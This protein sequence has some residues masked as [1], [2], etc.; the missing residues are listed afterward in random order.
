MSPIFNSFTVLQHATDGYY[1]VAGTKLN[2]NGNNWQ[3]NTSSQDAY[4]WNEND[5]N[6]RMSFKA[7]K[8]VDKTTFW[9][10]RKYYFNIKT[11]FN[12][13]I[14]DYIKWSD[15]DKEAEIQVAHM[16]A[17]LKR[18]YCSIVGFYKDAALTQPITKFSQAED[19]NIYVKY[20]VSGAPF[21]A[22][23][24]GESTASATWY[25]LTD[26]GSSQTDGKK[27][28]LNGTNFKNNG[29]NATYEKVSEFAFIGD[30][31]E[32][33]VINRSNNQ[34]VGAA[35]VSAGN[36][37]TTNASDAGAGFKWEIPDDDTS[38]SFVMRQYGSSAL[39]MYWQ[40]TTSSAG[41]NVTINT[42]NTRV[43]VMELEKLNYTFNVINLA[44]EI[45]ITATE[46]LEPFTPLTGYAGIPADIRSPFLADE[47]VK[48]YS[49]YGD[50]NSDGVIDRRDWHYAYD[51]GTK[52]YTPLEKADLTELP[53]T[54][55]NIYVSYTTS[56]LVDKTIKLNYENE[57]NVK[58]NDEYIYW[59]SG[60]IL[61]KKDPTSEEL[62]SAAYL[63][64]LRGRDPYSMLIDNKGASI[65]NWGNPIP[66]TLSITV[67]DTNGKGG[68]SQATVNQGM[69][70]QVSDGTWG[71]D[72]ALTFVDNRDVASRFVA[73]MS[74][75]PGV[76]EVLAAT[77][78]TELY[79]IGRASTAG[80]ETKIYSID[81]EN[82]GYAHGSDQLRFELATTTV[83]TY[84][85][86]DKN[87]EEL[88]EVTSAN[89]R[90]SFPSEYVSPLVEEY[91]YYST[92]DLALTDLPENRITEI[93][94]DS[95]ADKHVY[96]TYKVGSEIGFGT[97]HPYMLKF[98]NGK[99][100]KLED[101]ND[102]LIPGTLQAMYPY[103][104]GDGN[105]NIYDDKMN[106]EQLAGG[107]N[108]RP[109]WVWYLESDRSDPYHVKIR[110]KSTV[111][112][113]EKDNPTYL[114]TYAVHFDQETESPQKQRIVTGG[115]LAGISQVA[116]TEY[117]ILGSKNRYKLLTSSKVKAD[118]NGDGDTDDTVDRIEEDDRRY[119]TSFEQY[120]KTYNMV[121]Q[122]LLKDKVDDFEQPIKMP[123]DKWPDL[124]M[125][126]TDLD[127]N[128]EE[129]LNYVDGCSW[130]SY[131]AVASAIR[132]NG[133]N[134]KDG[135]DNYKKR[136]VERLEHW[137]QSFDM[138]DG[139]F[140]IISADIPPVLVL[141][142][143]HGWEIMRKPI[144]TGTSD[145]QADAKLA[146]LQVYDSPMVKEYKFYSNASK[147]K[148]CH[149]Y[150]LR[151]QDGAE[152]DPIKEDGK[153]FTSTSLAD[154]PQ[155]KADRDLFVTYT[156]KEEYDKSYDASTKESSA[157]IVLQNGTYATDGGSSTITGTTAP[158][159]LSNA[160]I[161][162]SFSN[163]SL[164]K[165]Q[166][167]KDIDLEMGIPIKANAKQDVGFDPYNLQLKNVSTEKFFTIDMRKS[168]LDGGQYNGDYTGGSL[169]VTL[170]AA[171]TIPVSS[172][173]SYD[174]ST[175]EMTNQTFMA[176]QDK[177]GNMQLM[178]R[179][180]HNRRINAF[181]TLA[182]PLQ[183]DTKAAVDDGAGMGAQTTFMV[184]P[185]VFS[186]QIIDNEGNVALCYKTAGES[187]P[188]IPEHFMS[189][190][191]T[192]F[193]Y[194]KTRPSYNSTTKTLTVSDEI[195]GSFAE[196]GI[197]SSSEIY[198]RY[199]YDEA[200]D[201]D[202][203]KILQGPWL[204]MSLGGE[205]QWVYY[206][207]T[208]NTDGA[209]FYTTTKPATSPT[210]DL[211]NAHQWHW[212]FL[213]SPC[214]AT[215]D[216]YIAPD[217]YAIKIFNRNANKDG[218]NMGVA[219]QVGGTERFVLLS[220]PNGDYALAACGDSYDSY[221]FLN[222]NGM[223]AHNADPGPAKHASL[224]TE[225]GFSTSSTTIS[226]DARVIFRDDVQHNYRYYVINNAYKCAATETQD[227]ETAISNGFYPLLPK[228]IQTE[229]LNEDDYLYYGTATKSSDT[230]TIDALTQ[231]EKLYGLYDDVIYVRY[232]EQFS[233]D[234]TPYNVPNVKGAEGSPAHVAR[235]A[236]S[237]D[238]AIDINGK[239]PYNIVWYDDNMMQ[240]I[241]GLNISYAA[242]HLLDGAES[243]TWKFDG[244]DPYAIQIKS[245]NDGGKFVVGE[246]ALANSATKTFMLL[247]REG[248]DYGVLAVTGD[249][250]KMLSG[251][252][253]QLV[254]AEAVEPIPP[255]KFII[256]ALSVHDLIYHLVIS[257]TGTPVT[258]TH[259][260][261][262]ETTYTEGYIWTGDERKDIP[263]TTQRDLVNYGF[264][265][266][267]AGKVSIGDVLEVPPIM[268]RPN[269]RYYYYVEG[270]YSDDDCA[271]EH[272]IAALENKYKGLEIT[273]LMSDAALIGTTVKINVAYSFNSGLPTNAGDGFVTEVK[274][275]WYTF[276]T[277]GATPYL[278]HYT[279]AL[280]HKTMPGRE[281]RFTNDYLWT[282]LGDAYG[283]KMYNRYMKKNSGSDYVMTTSSIEEGL[284]LT[285]QSDNR[286]AVYEL[287]SS[288]TPGYF[289]IHPVVNTGSPSYYVWKDPA[290][291][292]AK[293]STTAT[294][295]T[296]GLDMSLIQPYFDRVGYL[297]GLK[298]TVYDALVK[299]DYEAGDPKKDLYEAIENGTVTAAQLMTLQ[300]IVYNDD[301]IVA[302][303]PGYYRLHS[304]PGVSEINPVRYA[305][306]YLHEIEKTA[307][308]SSTPIPMHFYSRK[309]VNT[310]FDGDGGLGSGF[311]E[312]KATK[313]S[314]PIPATEYDPSTIF[315]I[316]GGI[317]PSDENDKINPRVTLSTQ[318]L[319]VKGVSAS[320]EDTEGKAVMT[321]TLGSAT[322]FSL[323][324][325]GGAVFLIHNGLTPI[326]REYFHFD[327]SPG[328]K[329]YDL[330]YYHNAPTDDAKWCIEP[331]DMQGLK[332]VTHDGGDGYFYT[333]LYVPFDVELPAD[334]GTN[335]Y[336][337]YI[338][339]DW[340]PK[341]LRPKKVGDYN[342]APHAGSNKF[343]PAGTQ[344]II[345]TTDNTGSVALKLPSN[346]P[347]SRLSS[348]IFEGKYLEQLLDEEITETKKNY[349]FGLPINGY[350][351][352]T[353]SGS[354]NGV[355]GNIINKD[356]EDKGVGFYLNATPNKE[357]DYWTPNNRYVLHNKIYYL[358]N[359]SPA[360]T[361][362]I[363]FVPVVFDDD[364][365]DNEFS[366][367]VSGIKEDGNGEDR[368]GY[369]N[370]V[371]DL[372]GRCVATEEQVKDGTWRMN[373]KPGIYIFNGKKVF[374][375]R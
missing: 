42:T 372:Q 62:A 267:H 47:T 108:T 329:K 50:L 244:G 9:E 362:G 345:R 335:K 260:T 250:N 142:D 116:A 216:Y 331:A 56:R 255:T 247:K 58:L 16:P 137:F 374:V 151:M 176:V 120:W 265:D 367:G 199:S 89:P 348:C 205:S 43:K 27:L 257:N 136:K 328:K 33:R 188:S 118:L 178:P 271:V 336:N 321:E 351:L 154:L 63:W 69:F 353:T 319:Y 125:A 315:Y 180:D 214:V 375:R 134:D 330:K 127:I 112:F 204:T 280:G 164:W 233:R 305:S 354:S 309:G 189:P 123:S 284:N 291:N 200:Q 88:L 263:G 318:D 11:Q 76:Y 237:N 169:N 209:G 177:K 277:S 30:P 20:E 117:M 326:S 281:T 46:A 241:D 212:K 73:M 6:V 126:L 254:D 239:L 143:R 110:S 37:L 295:W 160:I 240:T 146:A 181:A 371:Y 289:R 161:S 4:L 269:C 96:V 41:N 38:G 95:D 339:T 222:G 243:L 34:Y 232:P 288:S 158:A 82:G 322:T 78:T 162:S 152:R 306:G 49:S 300:K 346:S 282:P 159:N 109:R 130:H 190:L 19:Y 230:Y 101:G 23:Q 121:K 285:M 292:Y 352:T 174:H 94:D 359:S 36:T 211:S 5:N 149:Q 77:G 218:D 196:K 317:N 81:T 373:V 278:A 347:G 308:T 242:S 355:I 251:Y 153:H 3:P 266:H 360:P 246:A 283:F 337:A 361:R 15:Y 186:Y 304:Q 172:P 45:A 313:G 170:E 166:P 167:N 286:Y 60:T 340:D 333:T 268:E 147:V 193:K 261:G 182:D 221:Q 332:V 272:A 132:W 227:E 28:Q 296:F 191:A 365:E 224:V 83:I 194:Y 107:A 334:E 67:Y 273:K 220:H 26:A 287:L 51:A 144:P 103:C 133:Y 324:D 198:V 128:H 71:N 366:T 111:S 87:K 52:T 61:S 12:N 276:E 156:V 197:K 187:Y 259:R 131:E 1:A 90:L 55:G 215:S 14:Q 245:N 17:S 298:K 39:P 85:L 54:A 258:I 342:V 223:T 119:V 202:H 24:N 13:T 323:M 185:L 225:A 253:N 155:Y 370:R 8:D 312:T 213:Q 79:H 338:C 122:Y 325:I 311:T 297:G 114:Q 262:G 53:G 203:Y 264:A 157:F 248:Y 344:V 183:H 235:G 171:N 219:I 129:D 68:R 236:G 57:F 350:T 314:I 65:N 124:K 70:V 21:T 163:N 84:T 320:I 226:A 307:G 238:V 234:K 228:N 302:Y 229:L 369:D 18:K 115:N 168:I 249:Q 368:R 290:D 294:E 192:D 208:L 256:F 299:N 31:Y 358:Y 7:A 139:T 316:Q 184:R 22:L 66:N 2:V 72:K 252:G 140:D 138:G 201:N 148:D 106:E 341:I 165:I 301:N 327:Q 135:E 10:V 97:S 91:Y 64:Y 99:S 32:L 363:D 357:D 303:S 25:E 141:L 29:A 105:L 364:A 100:Y 270:I 343:I 195:T 113:S 310:T 175:L 98:W 231:I 217:P 293:L 104:N 44:G 40:W 179:F 210:D 75:K 207:G 275:L 35:T 145:S 86:I 150:T 349:A 102:N 48:F 173:E 206:N 279:N 92:K 74:N 274:D 59:S 93:V 80:A 356:P